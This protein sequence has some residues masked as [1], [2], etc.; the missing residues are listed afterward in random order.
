MKSFEALGLSRGL[1]ESVHHVGLE[2]PTPIQENAIPVL[3]ER[4]GDF[5]GLAQTGTGKTS[6]IGHPLSELCDPDPR[7][8]PAPALART[9]VLCVQITGG[10][11]RFSGSYRTFNIVAV[12]GGSSISDQIK[13][14]KK[15]AQ[16]IV[17]TPGPLIDLISRRAV[18]L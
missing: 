6:A 5:V 7:E 1:A 14:I 9:R 10:L 16:I 11:E 18:R 8:D 12:Y 13:K 15:G 4:N 17:A 2:K 3:L